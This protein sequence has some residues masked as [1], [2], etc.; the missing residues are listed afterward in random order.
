MVFWREKKKLFWGQIQWYVVQ[1]QCYLEQIQ[2]YLGANTVVFG[3][4]TV[5]FG[6]QCRFEQQIATSEQSATSGRAECNCRR[7]IPKSK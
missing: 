4:I 5:V 2:G 3:A 1:I 7:I 6:A